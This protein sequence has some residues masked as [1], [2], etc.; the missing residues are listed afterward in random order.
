MRL[1][2]RPLSEDCDGHRLLSFTEVRPSYADF[3]RLLLGELRYA[4]TL[5]C[6]CPNTTT[7]GDITHLHH[8]IRDTR[9]DINLRL[10]HHSFSTL[11]GGD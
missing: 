9:P 7:M 4:G 8:A 11:T 10:I 5:V 2:R 6:V 3:A 1:G